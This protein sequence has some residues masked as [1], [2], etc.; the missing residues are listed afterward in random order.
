MK[1]M[2]KEMVVMKIKLKAILEVN[3]VDVELMNPG[4]G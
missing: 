1:N 2:T 3:F 4:T